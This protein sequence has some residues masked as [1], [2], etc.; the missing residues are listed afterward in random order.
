MSIN[1]LVDWY[2]YYDML[3]HLARKS[4]MEHI[5]LSYISKY[6]PVRINYVS[7]IR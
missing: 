7:E 1:R 6:S 4:H 2:D 5:I 3:N